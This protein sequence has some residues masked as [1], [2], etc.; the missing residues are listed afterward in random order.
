[1]NSED[2][3]ERESVEFIKCRGSSIAVSIYN[4]T[5]FVIMTIELRWIVFLL[6][7]DDDVKE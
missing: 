7:D 6:D 5:E 1:V 2:W 4:S 3:K